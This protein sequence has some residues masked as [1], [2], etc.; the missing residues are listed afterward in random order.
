M[1]RNFC[2]FDMW[3]YSPPYWLL[4]PSNTPPLAASN[5]DVACKLYV[6]LNTEGVKIAS[7]P[8]DVILIRVVPWTYPIPRLIIVILVTLPAF[9]PSVSMVA[10]ATAPNPTP[11]I[12]T[13]GAV[14]YPEPAEMIAIE[15]ILPFCTIGCATAPEPEDRLTVGAL[16]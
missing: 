11:W 14:V 4:Y 12:L 6:H 8:T 5:T 10:R 1:K 15:M 13:S 7:W 2:G 9:S 3:A 16:V